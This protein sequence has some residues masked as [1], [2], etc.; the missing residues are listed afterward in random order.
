MNKIKLTSQQANDIE[1]LKSAYDIIKFE[2]FVADILDDKT[3]KHRFIMQTVSSLEVL[4]LKEILT[5]ILSGYE[6]IYP[7]L[8]TGDVVISKSS[9][10][11]CDIR[12]VEDVDDN[13]ILLVNGIQDRSYILPQDEEQFWNE[14]EILCNVQDRKDKR[15][16]K[17]QEEK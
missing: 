9:L 7:K 6:I 17:I 2:D 3:G 16:A 13:Y 8:K 11:S 1:Y 5:A 10:H 15:V 4:S 14:W 12:I